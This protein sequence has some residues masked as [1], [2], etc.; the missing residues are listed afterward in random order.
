M[1]VARPSRLVLTNREKWRLHADR[2]IAKL[3]EPQSRSCP[4]AN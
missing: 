2:S 4:N 1:S 3:P